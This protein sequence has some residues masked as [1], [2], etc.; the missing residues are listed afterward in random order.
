MTYFF[1]I[2]RDLL[3]CSVLCLKDNTCDSFALLTSLDKNQAHKC[4]SIKKKETYMVSEPGSPC[5]I[6]MYHTDSGIVKSKNILN[7]SLQIFTVNL[8]SL[9]VLHFHN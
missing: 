3:T 8:Q 6:I 4:I 7:S 2:P 9:A 1:Y 5:S